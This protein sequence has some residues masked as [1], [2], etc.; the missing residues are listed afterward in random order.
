MG[1]INKKNPYGRNPWGKIYGYKYHSSSGF[2][3]G[4]K[5]SLGITSPK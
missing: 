1:W 4:G 2:F 3:P 5:F